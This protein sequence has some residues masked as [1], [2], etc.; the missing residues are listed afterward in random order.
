MNSW[1]VFS[2]RRKRRPSVTSEYRVGVRGRQSQ[3]SAILLARVRRRPVALRSDARTDIVAAGRGGPADPDRSRRPLFARD[4]N[5]PPRPKTAECAADRRRHAESRGLRP[6]ETTRRRTRQRNDSRRRDPGN[7]GLHGA[8]TGKEHD[9]RSPD[10]HLRARQH[11]VLH[12]DGAATVHRA[13]RR[14]RPYDSCCTR[15]RFGRPG[16]R[17]TWT[18]TSKRSA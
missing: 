1:C 13:R 5:H 18:R 4:G 17:P 9:R 8:R 15:I 12:D 14:W 2:A 3:R 11:S 7:T 10:R 6:C 16:C